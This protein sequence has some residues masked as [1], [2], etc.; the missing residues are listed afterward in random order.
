MIQ[1]ISENI[2][3]KHQSN[4]ILLQISKKKIVK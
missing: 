1:F 3:W 4:Q 2:I